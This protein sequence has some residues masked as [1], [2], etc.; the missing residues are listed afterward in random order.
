M[1]DESEDVEALRGHAGLL[2][3]LLSILDEAFSSLDSRPILRL[4]KTIEEVRSFKED[5]PVSPLQNHIL[6]IA[7]DERLFTRDPKITWREFLVR[8]GGEHDV[9]N[10]RRICKQLGLRF[11][12][13]RPGR[14]RKKCRGIRISSP[15]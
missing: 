11:K 7:L 14:P 3:E 4:A 13:V 10:L 2:R 6:Y 1:K 5:G 8:V 12:Y 15:H 9:R